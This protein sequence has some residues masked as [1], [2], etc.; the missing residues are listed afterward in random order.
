MRRTFFPLRA[1][2]AASEIAVEVL[3]TPPFCDAIETIIVQSVIK[4]SWLREYSQRLLS[5]TFRVGEQAAFCQVGTD[6][7]GGAEQK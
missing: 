3:P 1:I 4:N 6:A 2:P 7:P 5:F